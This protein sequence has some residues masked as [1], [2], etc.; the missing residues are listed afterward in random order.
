MES[1]V[2]VDPPTVATHCDPRAKSDTA[3]PRATIFPLIIPPLANV[4]VGDADALR[5]MR[6]LGLDEET[7][8]SDATLERENEID[9]ADE[10]ADDRSDNLLCGRTRGVRVEGVDRGT[11]GRTILSG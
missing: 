11:V 5:R 8:G 6:I 7:G 2:K 10:E 3:V 1:P 9:D 4:T